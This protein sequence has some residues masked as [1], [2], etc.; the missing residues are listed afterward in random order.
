MNTQLDT[1]RTVDHWIFERINQDWTSGAFD[2]FFPRVTD[3][4]K[5]PVFLLC[6]LP[7]LVLWVYKK[8]TIGL[9]WILVLIMAVGLTDATSYRVIKSLVQRDR[10]Q[11]V[12]DLKV[13][14]RTHRHSGTSFPSN[15]AGNVFAA[16]TVLSAAFPPFWFLFFGVATSIA[17][18]RVYVGVHF[19]LDVASGALLG[20][21][22]AWS[23][24]KLLAQ[25]LLE[26]KLSVFRSRIKSGEGSS[27]ERSSDP[28]ATTRRGGIK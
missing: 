7:L 4:H 2:W 18:S 10:P 25:W 23:L 21:L 17:Y 16:A 15:H 19:P 20:M 22:I 3:L 5:S 11:F 12:S 14:L 28:S 1:L 9:K 24:R 26:A 8:R 27:R 13:E 6:M